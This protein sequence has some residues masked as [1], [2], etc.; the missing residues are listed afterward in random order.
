M[1]ALWPASGPA[2]ALEVAQ[3]LSGIRTLPGVSQR[4]LPKAPLPEVA[5]TPTKA[6]VPVTASNPAPLSQTIPIP[7]AWLPP[8]RPCLHAA[9]STT[10]AGPVQSQT[11][12]AP[13]LAKSLPNPTCLSH[14]WYKSLNTALLLRSGGIIHQRMSDKEEQ[15]PTLHNSGSV[16]TEGL[17]CRDSSKSTG[18]ARGTE[19]G[20]SKAAWPACHGTAGQLNSYASTRYF[21]CS[22][23]KVSKMFL[24]GNQHLF[25]RKHI[26][27]ARL[28]R[29][30][31]KEGGGQ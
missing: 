17:F 10:A 18:L 8:H 30:T 23:F 19:R 7:A 5:A 3:H 4:W 15:V 25:V 21:M 14:H 11:V 29:S 22:A 9:R 1:P 27:T 6:I 12:S 31:T 24:P 2:P 16:K 20:D 26:S 28:P 13:T